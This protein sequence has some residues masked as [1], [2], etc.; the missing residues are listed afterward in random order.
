LT[1]FDGNFL[2]TWEGPKGHLKQWFV[3]TQ[4]LCKNF[5]PTHQGLVVARTISPNGK[6]LFTADDQGFLKQWN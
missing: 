2:F 3:K 1:T 4:S 6:W 5:G